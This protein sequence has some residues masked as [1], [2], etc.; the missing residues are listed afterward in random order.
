MSN[1]VGNGN[2]NEVAANDEGDGKG[3]MSDGNGN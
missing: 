1:D 3:G 2:C